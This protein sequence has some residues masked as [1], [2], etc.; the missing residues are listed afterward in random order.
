M[1]KNV[2]WSRGFFRLWLVYALV[3]VITTG[4]IIYEEKPYYIPN[5]TILSLGNSS[6]ATPSKNLKIFKKLA[7]ARKK[8]A[9]YADLKDRQ[10][11]DKLYERF[12]SDLDRKKF[13]KQLG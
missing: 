6:K 10:L 9:E 2:S 5:T 3:V 13:N 12:Y 11:I 1:F 8:Y 7:E 4:V